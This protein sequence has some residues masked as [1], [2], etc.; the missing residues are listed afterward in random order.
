VGED[1]EKKAEG[2]ESEESYNS[3][4]YDD[5]G[6]YIWGKEGEDWEFYDEETKEEREKGLHSYIE[7]L[8]EQALPDDPEL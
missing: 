4:Y 1:V 6:R 2:E 7:T 5:E 3:E 8:N